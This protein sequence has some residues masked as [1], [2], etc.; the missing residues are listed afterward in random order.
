[1]NTQLIKRWNTTVKNGD[2]IYHLG[3]FARSMDPNQWKN[4]LNGRKVFIHGNHDQKLT[5]T[6]EFERLYYKGHNF[7]LTHYPNQRPKQWN[8]WVIHGHT[9]NNST[10][11][12]FIN[13]QLQTINVSCELIGYKPL[14]LDYLISLDINSIKR[15]ETIDSKPELY[16]KDDIFTLKAAE[17]PRTLVVG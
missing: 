10:K 9:H 12:S 13:G 11:Y 4:K 8:G 5:G 1:M 16:E 14:S 17:S 7:C 2:K 6:K 3:D 15:M